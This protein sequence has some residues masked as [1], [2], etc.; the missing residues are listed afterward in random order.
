MD[1]THLPLQRRFETT[2]DGVKAYVTYTES[3][4]QLDIRHTIVPDA[5][6]GRGIASAL[7]RSAYDYALS[8]RLRP[9][10]TCSYAA[11]W[12][13]RHPEYGGTTG[14][15]YREGESCAL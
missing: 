13:K 12:L 10:A 8:R 5:I 6:G 4:G 11:V 9:V 2:V 1:I 7:V 14:A 15:D 3:D